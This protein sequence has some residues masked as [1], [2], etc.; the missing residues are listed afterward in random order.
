MKKLNISNLEW[1]ILRIT[2]QKGKITVK[3]ISKA[4]S[5]PNK[6]AYTTIQTYMERM[7]EKG[8]LTKEK[9][10]LV[11][12]YKAIVREKNLINKEISKFTQNVFAGSYSNLAAYLFDAH[13]LDKEDIEMIKKM[14]AEKENEND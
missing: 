1:E 12:F 9:I 8:F 2:W 14:I 7:V 13:K 11:N 4:L 5:K 10:G 3:E 6:R